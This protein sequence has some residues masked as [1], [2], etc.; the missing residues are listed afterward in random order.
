VSDHPESQ[1]YAATT[2]PRRWRG[3]LLASLTT[4]GLLTAFAV[5]A[6]AYA[7]EA[8]IK[9]GT[10]RAI[11]GQYIVVLK[12]GADA[13]AIARSNGLRP[14]FVYSAAIDGFAATLSKAQLTKIRRDPSVAY[15]SP[16]GV[17]SVSG[18]PQPAPDGSETSLTPRTSGRT[19]DGP[20]TR[21]TQPG[22]TWGIDRVDQRTGTNGTYNYT[23]TGAGVRAY[24]IDTGIYTAHTQFGGRASVGFDSV[25]DGYNGQDCHGHGTHV[26][27]TIGGATYGLAK[28]VSLVAVRVLNCAGSGSYAGVIAGID[29]VTYTHS[30]P[31]VANMSLGGGFSAPV[32][33]AVTKS[34]AHGVTYAVAAGNENQNA[35][36]VSPASTPG[37]LTVGATTLSGGVDVRAWFSN[38][39]P[40][41]DV[42]DP[43]VNIT[44][45]WIGS[46]V[47]TNTI[48]GT[49][50]ASPHVAGLAVLYLQ[51]NP[52][53]T[54]AL[55]TEVLKSTAVVGIV[56][57]PKG[58]PNLFA[59]KWNGILTGTGNSSLHP[60]GSYWYQGTTGY[61]Q[62]WLSGTAGTD[63]DLYL[64]RWSGSAWVTVAG[65]ASFTPAERIVY[66]GSPGYYQFWVYAYSGG[67]SFDLWANHPA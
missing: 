33:D 52:Y 51:S 30:G 45:A 60:D 40:C 55:V 28:S 11:P 12:D 41:V 64:R 66:L 43:G 46:N 63:P 42:F 4:G 34:I 25:G 67:G 54:P 61:I 2:R 59:R 65:S 48:S 57:D 9:A 16:D 49:S 56:S 5:A 29:W 20:S 31:S 3:A 58:S 19:S 13:A 1:P 32:N 39:G 37:A 44:S 17:A 8:P 18:K 38:W 23:N 47:A 21:T 35:C 53:A 6:P 10:A 27:G 26:A 50:M 15:V 14:T 24:V 22:A 62:G 36:N 7:G